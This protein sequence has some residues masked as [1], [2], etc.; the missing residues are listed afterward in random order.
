MSAPLQNLAGASWPARFT[1]KATAHGKVPIGTTWPP[2]ECCRAVS[3]P[4][5]DGA[6]STGATMAA[7]ATAAPASA[8]VRGIGARSG[9]CAEY[10]SGWGK[11]LRGLAMPSP[12]GKSGGALVHQHWEFA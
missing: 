6:A 12:I 8:A 11:P 10:C 2:T 7:A 5:G 3:A 4:V 9:M 1:S